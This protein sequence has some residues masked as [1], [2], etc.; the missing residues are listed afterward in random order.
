MSRHFLKRIFNYV[1][2]KVNKYYFIE[3]RPKT[4]TGILMKNKQNTHNFSGR[5]MALN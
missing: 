3:I 1:Q 4:I 5:M 2:R